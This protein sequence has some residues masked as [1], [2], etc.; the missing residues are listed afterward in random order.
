MVSASNQNPFRRVFDTRDSLR[1]CSRQTAEVWLTECTKQ[2]AVS[3]FGREHAR[4]TIAGPG[5]DWATVGSNRLASI[6]LQLSNLADLGIFR[7]PGWH[8]GEEDNLIQT[9]PLL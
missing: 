1:R 7:V 5:R 9:Q 3:C 4:I 6:A 2:V 8:R